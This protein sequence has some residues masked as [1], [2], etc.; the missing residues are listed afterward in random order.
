MFRFGPIRILLAG[1]LVGTVI[2]DGATTAI[3][4]TRRGQM[5]V[6]GIV[7]P[8]N[9][10]AISTDLPVRVAKIHFREAQ[11]FRKGAVL[12][13]F[14][15][16]RLVAEHA[17]LAAVHR[18]QQLVL[19]SNTYLDKRGAVGKVEVEISR[20]RV[21][22]TEADAKALAARLK[23]CTI[24]APY[25][26]RMTELRINEHEIPASGQP[27]MSIVDETAFEIDLIMPSSWLRTLTTGVAIDFTIDETGRS[28]QA[29]V[30]R[31]GAAVDPV[32]QTVK[33][34]AEFAKLDDRVLAGMTGTA[35][36]SE[37]A[38]SK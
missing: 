31:I 3:G 37:A 34:I 29:R 33:V 14:D 8:I 15:C 16:E 17:A 11:S 6:R 35:K 4:D 25:D 7:R 5:P 23:Q 19:E 28:Y 2:V 20:T 18:E 38:A 10:A 12:I 27:F 9:Q 32:S 24:I 26:G 22:K 30:A 13:T 21:Q 1:V 36:F